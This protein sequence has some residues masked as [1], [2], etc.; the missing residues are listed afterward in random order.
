MH[1]FDISVIVLLA[2]STIYSLVR[3]LIKELFSLASFGVAFILSHRYYS[4]ISAQISSFVQNK[5]L[6]DLL[7]FGFV[8][9]LT[10]LIVGQIG[11][12]VRNLLY[13][14]KTLT[15][16]D[17]VGGSLLGLIKG[18]LIITVIMIPIGLI[19]A[20]KK[21]IVSKS[22]LAP[23]ILNISREIS[24][25]SF[26]DK[27]ILE[28]AQNKIMKEMKNKFI[29]NMEDKLKLPGMKE[30][31]KEGLDAIK[32]SLEEMDKEG[33]KDKNKEK[34]PGSKNK[35]ENVKDNGEN[36]ISEN[37]TKEDNR[38]LNLLLDKIDKKK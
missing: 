34:S 37:I 27:N 1:W 24:K 6:S 32:G 10:V 20:A 5:I 29:E 25:I 8:F 12:F 33:D 28:S 14:T 35:K 31:I 11:K 30:K 13:E 9:I 38:K 26:S 15:I 36:N 4:F 3:G 2:V 19:P 17:R 21:A 23:F 22:K 18:L 7:S 16:T